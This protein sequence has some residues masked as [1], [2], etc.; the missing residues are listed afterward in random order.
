MAGDLALVFAYRDG[1]N[2]APQLPA[3]WT[4]IASSGA[5][6][7]SSRVGRRVLQGG[8][9]TT[10]V[11]TNATEVQVL[12]V[13]GQ[14]PITPI[15]AAGALPSGA[16]ASNRITYPTIQIFDDPVDKLDRRVLRTPHS[17]QRQHRG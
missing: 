7:N 1:S 12:V 16:T 10:G 11:W 17:H 15:G 3:G 6:T 13:R 9:T 5:N 2:T 8:D 4:N 14:H